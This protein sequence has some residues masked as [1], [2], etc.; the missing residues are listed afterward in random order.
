MKKPIKNREKT[1]IR[2]SRILRKKTIRCMKSQKME[3]KGGKKKKCREKKSVRISNNVLDKK[4]KEKK[5]V[6]CVPRSKTQMA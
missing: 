3:W 5:D 1:W 2:F 4:P 6:F